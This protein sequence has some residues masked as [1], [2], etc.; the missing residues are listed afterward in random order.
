MFSFVL[1]PKVYDLILCSYD[2][3]GPD[4]R[5][6]VIKDCEMRLVVAFDEVNVRNI[7]DSSQPCLKVIVTVRDVQ[8]RLVEEADSLGIKIVR[9]EDIEKFGAETKSDLCPPEPQTIATICFSR[10][11]AAGTKLLGRPKGVIL[12]HENIVSATSAA[13][14]QL[15]QYAPASTDTLYSYLP[16]SHTLERCCELSVFMAGGAVGFHSGS[17]KFADSDMKSLKPTI[18]PAVPKFLNRIY[19]SCVTTANKER[20]SFA[21]SQIFL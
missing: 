7:L 15:G 6:V 13:I 12:S 2:S 20:S 21:R 4:A 10:L 19:D 3:L 8:P 17:L 16:L 1:L 14:L 9:F 5:S 11:A 18:L